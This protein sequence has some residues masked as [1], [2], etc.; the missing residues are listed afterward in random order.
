MSEPQ[1]MLAPP[2][3]FELARQAF[4]DTHRG[5]DLLAPKFEETPY[6]TPIEWLRASLVRTDERYPLSAEETRGLDLACGTG[7]AVRMLRRSCEEVVGIDFSSG[8]LEQAQRFSRGYDGVSYRL[9]DLQELSIAPESFDRIVTFGAWGHILPSFRERL[10]HQIVGALRPGGTF[11]TLTTDE[12]V[13]GEKRFWFYLLFDLAIRIRNLI[14]F[15]EFH[16]YYRL[17]S[18]ARLMREL[19]L[20]LKGRQDFQLSAEPL[21]GFEETP[22]A[23]VV[24]YR[25]SA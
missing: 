20:V 1:E 7:R 12:P 23:L 24:V 15:G 8:M 11:V 10:L 21:P 25:P 19:A 3:F 18:T 16:M 22:L 14:W 2:S 6:A 13:F 5:Y 17:N 4:S 9:C